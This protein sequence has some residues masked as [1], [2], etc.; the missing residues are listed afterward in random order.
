MLTITT[1]TDAKVAELQKMVGMILDTDPLLRIVASSMTAVMRK[2]VHEDGKAA[3]GADI[4]TYS[5]D[6]MNTRRK[7]NRTEDRKIILSLTRQMENDMMPLPTSGGWGIGYSN[8]FNY[9]KAIW[10]EKRE[11]QKILTALSKEEDQQ[12]TDIVNDYVDEIIKQF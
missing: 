9:E 8:P 5:E 12:V 4:G 1:N 3:D 7:N 11:N 10:N 6:Y 2:R